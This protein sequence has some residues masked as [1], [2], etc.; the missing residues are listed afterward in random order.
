MR[1]QERLWVPLWWWLVIGACIVVLG[2]ELHGGLGWVV[3]GYVYAGL[4][5]VVGAF[6]W[7]WSSTRV[8]VNADELHAGPARL[9]LRYV[10]HVRALDAP[11][12]R[13]MRG[14][15]AD[16]TAHMLLRPYLPQAVY[17][18]IT[19]P[20][21]PTPYWLVATRHPQRLAAALSADRPGTDA[22]TVTP[23]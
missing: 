13:R 7:V 12:A 16:P 15:D 22:D 9:P 5:V 1:Y 23:T 3:A 18:E 8:R 6:L 17:I 11:A 20:A 4:G 21:D 10:G 19:D 14:P 2:A